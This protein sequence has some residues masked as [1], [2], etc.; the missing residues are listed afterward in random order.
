VG[1]LHLPPGH[2]WRVTLMA[3][4]AVLLITALVLVPAGNLEPDGF[5][6]GDDGGATGAQPTLSSP[7]GQ[8]Q[9]P[10]DPLAL[11]TVELPPAR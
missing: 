9:W 5:L 3:A 4:L 7:A 2:V 1:T 6:S 8:G 11:P 10:E